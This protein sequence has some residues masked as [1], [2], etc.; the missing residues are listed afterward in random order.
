MNKTC[1][2]SQ[3]F[4]VREIFIY[5]MAILSFLEPFYLTFL[6]KGSKKCL[7]PTQIQF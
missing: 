4:K 3:I 6:F 5:L 2:Q 7:K 1:T